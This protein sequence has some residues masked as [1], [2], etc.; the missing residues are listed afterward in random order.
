MCGSPKQAKRVL[1]VPNTTPRFKKY[2]LL[3]RL[4]LAFSS[5]EGGT[6][7][8]TDEEKQSLHIKRDVEGAVP[9][10]SNVV[11]ISTQNKFCLYE[12]GRRGSPKRR[13][14]FGGSRVADGEGETMIKPSHLLPQELSPRE[15]LFCGEP[16]NP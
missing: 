2:V 12:A 1:G 16:T 9:Y 10:Q 14:S 13:M 3:V 8:V 4:R 7:S 6:R 11:C 5:G 15:S